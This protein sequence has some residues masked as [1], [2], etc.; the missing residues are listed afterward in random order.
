MGPE[1]NPRPSTRTQHHPQA[2]EEKYGTENPIREQLNQYF[3]QVYENN[4]EG[5]GSNL[6][7]VYLVS[8]IL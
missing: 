3:P 8:K 1:D 5:Y 2:S 7:A 6:R 4:L